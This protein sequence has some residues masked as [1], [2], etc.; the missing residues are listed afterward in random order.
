MTGGIFAILDDIALLLDD[1]AVM[2][3]VAVKKT[4]GVLG[5]DL[6]VNAEK[7]TG[8]PAS[9]ELPVLWAITKGSFINKVIILPLA[10][11]LSAYLPVLIIPVL[12]LGGAY[13]CYE[14]AEKIYHVLAHPKTPKTE[15]KEGETA[16][17]LPEIEK[18]KDQFSNPNRLYPL[19]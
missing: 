11:L 3:K 4:A 5:D 2:S 14:G 19:Y 17:R 1:A 15:T 8:F 13:L 12:L 7:A 16:T 9:R 6:A 18:E 10:F